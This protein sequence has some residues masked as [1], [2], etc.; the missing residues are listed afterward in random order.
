[1]VVAKNVGH[2]I[3]SDG[4]SIEVWTEEGHVFL[5]YAGSQVGDFPLGQPGDNEVEQLA[6]RVARG[7]AKTLACTGDDAVIDTNDDFISHHNRTYQGRH[8][9][10]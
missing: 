1:M 8:T 2:V 10:H 4:L 3:D 6:D 9:V 7:E 5:W